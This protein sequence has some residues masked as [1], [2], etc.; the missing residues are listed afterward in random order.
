[1]VEYRR[2]TALKRVLVLG[3]LV[4]LGALTVAVGA[5]RQTPSAALNQVDK[6]RDNLYVLR[7]DG[8]NT[9]AFIMR[10]S[11]RSSKGFVQ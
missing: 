10:I 4:A 2:T 11:G 3:A 5:A 9:A 8:G 7:G 1:M 6:I